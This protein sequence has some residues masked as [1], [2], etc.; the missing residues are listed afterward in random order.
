MDE[1]QSFM[2]R[3]DWVFTLSGIY[4]V[5]ALLQCVCSFVAFNV[6]SQDEPDTRARIV[7]GLTAM[8]GG[9]G[10]FVVFVAYVITGILFLIMLYHA[11]AKARGFKTPFTYCSAG[12]AAGCWFIP[13]V[14]LVMPYE[15]MRGMLRSAAGSVGKKHGDLI[16]GLWWGAVVVKGV[17]GGVSYVIKPSQAKTLHDLATLGLLLGISGILEL[18]CAGL[19][20]WMLREWRPLHLAALKDWQPPNPATEIPQPSNA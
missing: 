17:Y 11:C 5:G 7:G 15:V 14:N 6:L 18:L 20:L 1:A 8:L 10:S 13:F 12:M 4:M 16:V 9:I 19:F 2:K 3:M